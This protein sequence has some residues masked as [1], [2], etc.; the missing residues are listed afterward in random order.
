MKIPLL[1]ALTI[2]LAAS[3][4]AAS[5]EPTRIVFDT[6]MCGDYD[7]VGAL[8]VLNALADDGECEI[9]AVLSSSRSSPALGMCEIINESYERTG[10]PMG[11]S[12]GIGYIASEEKGVNEVFR[13]M[14]AARRASLR[15]PNSDDAPDANKVYRRLLADS[16][17]KSVTLCVVGFTTNI[18]RLLVTKGAWMRSRPKGRFAKAPCQSISSTSTLVAMFLRGFLLHAKELPRGRLRKRSSAA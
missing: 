18:R 5:A 1:G 4:S 17:D 9:I 8:A 2:L 16:P 3:V 10:I 14:V 15:Y 6:D 7:D 11:V 13:S 12:K